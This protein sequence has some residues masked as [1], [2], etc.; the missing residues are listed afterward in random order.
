MFRHSALLP[1]LALAACKDDDRDS[2]VPGDG[3]LWEV[4]AEGLDGPADAAP[5][6]D[7]VDVFWVTDGDVSQAL[8]RG[9]VGAA[10]QEV[11]SFDH[12]RGVVVSADGATVFIGDRAGVWS[13]PTAG[14]TPERMP[15]TEGLAVA[16]LDRSGDTLLATGT[17]D[18]AGVVVSLVGGAANTVAQGFQGT[19]TGAL[20]LPDGRHVVAVAES[21]GYGS[22]Y[23][24]RE[25]QATRLVAGMTVGQPTGLALF[26]DDHTVMVSSLAGDGSAQVVLVDP[27][28]GGTS[29]YN[30]VVSENRGA[31]GLHRA[32]AAAV[33]TWA[34]FARGTEGRVYSISPCSGITCLGNDTAAAVD[35]N[36]FC[37]SACG[38]AYGQCSTQVLT[39]FNACLDQADVDCRN[40][41][42]CSAAYGACYDVLIPAQRACDDQQQACLT[43]T[44]TG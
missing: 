40:D 28:T 19:P 36:A 34:G 37:L 3:L 4:V 25:G 11:A 44:C 39:E 26:G 27:D 5:G 24:V 41:G 9:G 17:L 13:L 20:L 21:A 35:P 33:W 10:P 7:G 30:E 22:L 38:T 16:H 18:G 43:N 31:G 23:T 2:A 8:F 32:E 1:L 29:I 15:G 6:P 42:D 14:G 12:P